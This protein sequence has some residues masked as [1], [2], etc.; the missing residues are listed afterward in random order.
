MLSLA[1]GEVSLGNIVLVI[2]HIVLNPL[3]TISRTVHHR[4]DCVM[5]HSVAKR[6]EWVKDK[7][8]QQI[9]VVCYINKK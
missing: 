2:K 1:Y 9:I 8:H 7:C 3:H 6:I 5:A 4:T